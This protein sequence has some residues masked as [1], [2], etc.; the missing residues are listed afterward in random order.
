[1]A[2]V[3][4][5][6]AQLQ[7]AAAGIDQQYAGVQDAIEQGRARL[8]RTRSDLKA[9]TKVVAARRLETR[10]AALASYQN[11]ELDTTLQLVLTE[12]TEG[13]LS[14][15]ST[16]QNVTDNQNIALQDFSPGTGP[17]E[18]PPAERGH[19]ARGAARA[20]AQRYSRTCTKSHYP[21]SG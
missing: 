10:R 13:L 15:L 6:V 2:Q 21:N 7:I 17:A 16:V 4:A 9:Q 11:R 3:K 5:E 8:A 19:R 12:D 18:R 20:A 1:M 14:Q